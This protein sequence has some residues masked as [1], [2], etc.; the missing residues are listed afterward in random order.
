MIDTIWQSMQR[1]IG[2][3]LGRNLANA[4]WHG[5]FGR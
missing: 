1:G 3:T 4:I 2:W 5:M